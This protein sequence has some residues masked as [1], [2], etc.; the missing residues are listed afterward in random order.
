MTETDDLSSFLKF[1][2]IDQE[3][4]KHLREI[5]PIIMRELPVIL[6]SFYEH[7]KQYPNLMNMFRDKDSMARARKAQGAHWQRLFSG[8]FDTAY[9]ESVRAVGQRHAQL[10]LEPSW[11]IGG[12]SFVL[13]RLNAV[14]ARA[15]PDRLGRTRADERAAKQAALMKA[16]MLDMQFAISIYLDEAKAEKQRLLNRAADTFDTTIG[17]ISEKIATSGTGLDETAKTLNTV[18]S[19]VSREVTGLAS[20]AQQT[21]DNVVTVAT[22]AEQLSGAISEIGQQVNHSMDIV[23]HASDEASTA[24]AQVSSLNEAADK[25]GNVVNL[26]KDIAAQTNLLALNATIEAARAGEAGKGFAVVAGEV[27]TLA[28]QTTKAT[29]DITEHIGRVQAATAE[30][31]E[32]IQRIDGTIHKMSEISH[33]ISSAVEEQSAAT[34]EIARNV[35]DAAQGTQAVSHG[36]NDINDNAHKAEDA[37]TQVVAAAEAVSTQAARLREEAP[38]FLERLKSGQL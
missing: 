29:E 28:N 37:G 2:Q 12:Y 26:I 25:I 10:N 6:D 4:R 16:A 15:Y 31:V 35:H 14:I 5:E 23:T 18:A 22:A 24:T 33:S 19:N 27:K 3:T 34:N 11:Y 38:A 36:V 30:A 21:N 13:T 9:M 7:M 17:D 32:A 8:R 20:H 1:L